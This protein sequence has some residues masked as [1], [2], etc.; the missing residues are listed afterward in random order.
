MSTTIS[1]E[2]ETRKRGVWVHVLLGLGLFVGLL[3]LL[4]GAQHLPEPLATHW[5]LSGLPN[6]SMSKGALILLLVALVLPIWAFFATFL[7]AFFVRSLDE[8]LV[9][10]ASDLS[11]FGETPC[12][13]IHG[14]F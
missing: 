8:V 2:S 4:I 5:G 11:V 6:G 3:P 7:A 9:H 12:L 10:Q 1:S 13:R 14:E